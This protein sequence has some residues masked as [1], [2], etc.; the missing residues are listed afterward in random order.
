MNTIRIA[1]WN[2]NSIK[3]RLP[4]LLQWLSDCEK[5]KQTIDLIGLQELK[6]TED[7]FPYQALED[8]GYCSLALGQ[9]TYNGVALIARK[10][11]LAPLHQTQ[12]TIFLHA[13]KNIPDLEDE[14]QRL[15]ASTIQFKETT[16]IRVIC[17][18]FPNGQAPGSEKFLYK[19]R[20]LEALHQFLKT[21]LVKFPRLILMGDFNIAPKDEDVHDPKV[22]E[23][24]NLVSPEE[25][26]FFSSFEELGLVDSYRLFDQA[27]KS[28]SWWDYRMMGFRRNAGL[29][30][31]HIMISKE[32]QENCSSC[33]IDTN[34]RT[35]EQ[36][37]DHAPVILSLQK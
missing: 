9:K 12:E 36:P 6:L 5:N 29:R 17:A 26:A 23:G 13:Q 7:K 19:M 14:Q 8:I 33:N 4:H 24:Q 37:S 16:P 35:W 25:R 3:V 21:E 34:P 15:I 11:S 30:I 22:W 20:W 1:T 31:D 32:L 2:V 27:P 10:D 28:F 18:Y